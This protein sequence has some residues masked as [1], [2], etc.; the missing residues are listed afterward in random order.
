MLR[1]YPWLRSKS[2]EDKVWEENTLVEVCHCLQHNLILK[3]QILNKY[4]SDSKIIF[5][6]DKCWVTEMRNCSG[7]KIPGHTS[8]LLRVLAENEINKIELMEKFH[9]FLFWVKIITK[10]APTKPIIFAFYLV[11]IHSKY[12][13][14]EISLRNQESKIRDFIFHQSSPTVDSLRRETLHATK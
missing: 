7:E 12:I 4:S 2:L 5:N 8:I 13:I 3:F 9:I 1:T 14:L 6:W 10:V 11:S